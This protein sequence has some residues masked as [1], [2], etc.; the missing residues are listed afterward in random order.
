[1]KWEGAVRMMNMTQERMSLQPLW[2]IDRLQGLLLRRESNIVVAEAFPF[3]AKED[4]LNCVPGLGMAAILISTEEEHPFAML[5]GPLSTGKQIP[6]KGIKHGIYCR[7]M[8]GEI[9]RILY[10]PGKEL[11]DKEVPLTEVLPI[12]DMLLDPKEAK[13]LQKWK[14]SLLE[15]L[16]Q[17]NLLQ[18]SGHLRRLT[19]YLI[20]EII[21][22]DGKIRVS[23]LS[24]KTGYSGRYLQDVFREYVG[25]SPKQLCC[26][27]RFQKSLQILLNNP[28]INEEVL[29][30]VSGYYDVS[31]L[32]RA[33]KQNIGMTPVQLAKNFVHKSLES[34]LK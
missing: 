28:N 16:T 15:T 30:D 10:I 3:S 18:R 23:E 1:M 8:P 25:L 4:T 5:C 21:C 19:Q 12:D 34:N 7:F 13:D 26:N 27:V 24:E 29:S 11:I 2:N 22:S 31:H 33:Y 32:N 6:L 9:S 20:H 14:D 17:K